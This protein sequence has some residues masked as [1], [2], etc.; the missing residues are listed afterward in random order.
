M[1]DLTPQIFRYAKLDPRFQAVLNS[2]IPI[3]Y[4][5]WYP[6]AGG[7][8]HFEHKFH[9]CDIIGPTIRPTY[10]DQI[11]FFKNVFRATIWF[12]SIDEF[13]IHSFNLARCE[14]CDQEKCFVFFFQVDAFRADR[15]LDEPMES[16][17]FDPNHIDTSLFQS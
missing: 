8:M 4:F 14:I 10:T 9:F 15:F 16:W 2:L 1:G 3:E 11:N 12:H 7:Y 17:Q 6:P 5:T 13:K